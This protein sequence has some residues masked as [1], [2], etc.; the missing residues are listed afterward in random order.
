[1]EVHLVCSEQGYSCD[2]AH[3]LRHGRAFRFVKLYG[4]TADARAGRC[5]M[6]TISTLTCP[7]CGKASTETMPTDAC[8]YF[9]DCPHCNVVLKPLPGDCCVFCSYAN[10]PMPSHSGNDGQAWLG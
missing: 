3:R 1:M 6:Q 10:I 5:V 8:Q 9:Y 7:K 4:A 2:A